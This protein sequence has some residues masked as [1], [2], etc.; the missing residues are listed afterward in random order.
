MLL[1][2]ASGRQKPG[3]SSHLGRAFVL[4]GLLSLGFWEERSFGRGGGGVEGESGT[5]CAEGVVWCV[6]VLEKARIEVQLVG[7]GV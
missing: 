6:E 1:G 7:D 2:T 4:P 5:S 3:R